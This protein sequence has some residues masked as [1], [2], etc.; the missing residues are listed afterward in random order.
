MGIFDGLPNPGAPALAF[1]HGMV[2]GRAEREDREV[3]GALTAYALN[4]DDPKA[5]E[6]IAQYRPE[7]AI[8]IRQDRDKRQQQAEVADL[9]RRAAAGDRTAL[10]QLA[11][12]DINA[13]DKLSDNE[14]A[15]THERVDAIGQAA[16]RISQL[17]PE[18]QP[19]A[20]DAAVDQLST[21]YPEIAELKGHYSPE[22]L[23]GAIDQAKL[24]GEF[25][26]LERP[27]YQVIPEG[28]T[29]VNTR[30]PAAIETFV[31]SQAGPR[32]GVIEDGYR[33]K[34]GNPADPSSWE[35]VAGGGVGNGPSTFHPI[36]AG[37]IDL[38][39]RP[40]V[41]NA[42]GSISTVRSMSFGTD[43][44]EVLV[45]T[46]SDDGRI[47]SDEEAIAN[48]R[49]TG[50][51]LGIFRTADEATAYAQSL[52][53]D[54]ANEYVPQA[55]SAAARSKS[56]TPQEA[57][58]IRQSLGPNGQQAFEKWVRDNHIVIGAR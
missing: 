36:V 41:R 14:R 6:A 3:R 47:L 51:H 30:D 2:Q 48:Y 5:F 32:P 1:Q 19:V 58:T 42:D 50:K 44:G 39:N 45:P 24:A 21:R 52:H 28:G 18:Q 53:D 56:I 25:L 54:Q 31:G 26:A 49:R 10:A 22:A 9:Q 15:A 40:I 12:F 33:F 57:A 29:L 23:S 27:N 4:P 55:L 8:Q 37:N 13:W 34:G 11:G 7:V 46:V 16:L 17:P 43:Q 20:W 35:P 38:H